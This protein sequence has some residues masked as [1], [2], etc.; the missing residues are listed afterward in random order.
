MARSYKRDSRGRFAGGGGGSGGGSRGG[1]KSKATAPSKAKGKK[2]TAAERKARNEYGSG[3]VAARKKAMSSRLVAAG[4]GKGSMNPQ[5]ASF[6]RAQNINIIG[7]RLASEGKGNKAARRAA[8]VQARAAQSTRVK[9]FSG[10]SAKNTAARDAYKAAASKAR[11]MTKTAA[12]VAAKS[13]KGSKDAKYWSRQA[14]GAKSGL[15]KVAKR[16]SGK[17]SRK[18]MG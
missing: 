18:R 11:T 4:Q 7:Q 6:I 13:G 9:Q 17:S 15:T 14:A 8:S 16:L 2:V 3:V 5:Q 12:K 10:K 1:G